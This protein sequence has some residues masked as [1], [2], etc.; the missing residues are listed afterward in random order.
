[1]SIRPPSLTIH[2]MLGRT[3]VSI[4]IPRGQSQQVHSALLRSPSW[5]Q[6]Q[7]LQA[8]V[9]GLGGA[10]DALDLLLGP[11]QLA[12]QVAL[13]LFDV[14]LLHSPGAKKFRPCLSHGWARAREPGP[15]HVKAGQQAVGRHSSRAGALEGADEL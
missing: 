13:L 6:P 5:A 11:E 12:L 7:A 1:M 3:E 14:V 10:L 8:A 4:L 2:A 15:Q 9:S